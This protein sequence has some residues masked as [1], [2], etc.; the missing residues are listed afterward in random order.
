MSPTEIILNN[1]IFLVTIKML[2]MT[3]K[4]FYKSKYESKLLIV[5]KGFIAIYI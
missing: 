1:K 2:Y 5:Y 3:S 4:I